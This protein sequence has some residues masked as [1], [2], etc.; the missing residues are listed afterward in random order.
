MKNIIKKLIVS[1]FVLAFFALGGNSAYALGAP[2]VYQP[3][4]SNITSTSAVLNGSVNPNGYSTN[5]WF[6]TPQSGG[7]QLFFQNLGSGTSPV[8]MSSYTMTGLTPNTTYSFGVTATNSFGNSYSSL[9]SFTTTGNNNPPPP[10]LPSVD[11][12]ANNT[13]LPSGGSTTL[14]WDAYNA[15]AC[16]GTGGSNGWSGYKNPNGGSFNTGALY[17]T[18]TYNITCTNSSGSDSDSVTVYVTQAPPPPQYPTV[19]ITANP[20]NV[21]YNGSSTISW[22][23]NYAT[24]CN[25]TGGSNGWSGPKNTSGTFY[26]GNLTSDKTYNITCTNS[27]G[28]AVD[29]VTVNVGNQPVQNPTVNLTANPMSVAYN[30][31]SMLSW[32]STNA[33]SCNATGG[34]NGWSGPKNTS[35]TFYTGNL[36][37][38]TSYNITCINS[39]G[40]ASDSVTIYVSGQPVQNPTVNLTTNQTD[41]NSGGSATLSWTSTNATSCTASGGSNGWAGSKP[42]SGTFYTGNLNYTTTYSITCTNNSGSTTDSVVINVNN[43]NTNGPSINFTAT[44]ISLSFNGSTTLYWTTSGATSCNGTN[45]ANGWAGTKSTSGSFF[46]GNLT[47]TTV[48]TLSCTNNYGTTTASVTVSVGN[49]NNDN[50]EDRPSVSTKNATNISENSATLNGEVENWNFRANE[51]EGQV[52][53]EYSDDRDDLEDNDGDDTSREDMD[54]EDDF[55]DRIS[56]LRRDTT[57]YFRAVA[58]NDS[59]TDYGNIRSFRTSDD[60]GNN[61]NI[62]TSGQCSPQAITT[63]ATNIGSSSARLNGLGL[64]NGSTVTSGYFEWGSNTSL[65]NTTASTIVGTVGSNPYAFSLFGL[66][67]NTTY[68]YR[69]VVTNQYGI[70][71]GDIVSFRTSG[72]SVA[73]AS[74]TIIRNTTTV[75]GGTARPSLVFLSVS[76]NDEVISQGE[77]VEYVVNYKNISTKNLRD[78]VIQVALPKELQFVETSR[79]YFSETNNTV[80]VNIGDLF[81]NEEGTVFVTARVLPTAQE[82]KIIV[83]TANLAYT[84]VSDNTQ[85]EVFAYSKNTIGNS[86]NL[87]GAAIFGGGFLPNS[88]FGWL[89]LLLILLLIILAARMAYN[90]GRTQTIIVPPASNT[91]HHND[92]QYAQYNPN[93]V[94]RDNNHL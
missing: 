14:N 47:Q 7:Q 6:T 93:A 27:S 43:Q 25:A 8:T 17:N 92:T 31:T 12:Y 36:T 71:R 84:I 46:T 44:D 77:I 94:H 55:S 22:N 81:P 57:Y 4:A 35:G 13:N 28:S 3:H 65:G 50:D 23:S 89:L 1:S 88:L 76:H 67:S 72:G 26:T 24:S 60:G 54:D 34:S 61:G 45:G 41:V 10:Q 69:A 9:I 18:T 85:E 19:N 75:V 62:C 64:I 66:S 87:G 40:S 2:I 90:H 83:V 82:G 5:A 11:L 74:T 80:V 21:A 86:I 59:G 70:S 38:T 56:G 79:G 15:T 91:A 73:G 48:F 78:V 53:F 52:W 16:N 63:L 58:R 49:D 20:M 39:S 29:S 42:L 68:F 51:D 37:N 30:G 33:T 32:N